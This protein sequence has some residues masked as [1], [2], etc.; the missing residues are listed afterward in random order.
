MNNKGNIILIAA[1]LIIIVLGIAVVFANK[2]QRS[3]VEKTL[4]SLISSQ[5]SSLTLTSQK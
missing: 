5:Y 2:Y 1:T 4:T 3:V